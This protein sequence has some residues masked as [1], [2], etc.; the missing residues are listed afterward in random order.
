MEGLLLKL[1]N[2]N[3]PIY[4]LKILLSYL[5]HRKFVVSVRGTKS[6]ENDIAAGVPQGSVLGPVLFI[7]FINDI[8][9]SVATSSNIPKI[10]IFA[11]DTAAHVSSMS[12]KLAVTKL[13]EYVKLLLDFFHK[14]K[15]KVNIEKTEHIIFS[16]RNFKKGEGNK[17]RHEQAL[18]FV[19]NNQVIE[20]KPYVK[21]L[22]GVLYRKL[23]FTPYVKRARSNGFKLIEIIQPLIG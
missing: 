13:T 21:Y 22:G 16:T 3:I 2:Y 18:D 4:I 19:I 12:E 11:D 17:K 23:K 7:Y 6:L 1:K 14:C 8:P 9:R 5:K 10:A 15:L 20:R